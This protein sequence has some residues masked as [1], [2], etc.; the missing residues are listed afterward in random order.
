[1]G[2]VVSVVLGVLCVVLL[3]V[4]VILGILYG[5]SISR[6]GPGG[7]CSTSKCLADA[8]RIQR[9][10]NTSVDPCDNFYDFACGNFPKDTTSVFGTIGEEVLETVRRLLEEPIENNAANSTERKM[11]EYYASCL[12]SDVSEDQKM[13][14]LRDMVKQIGGFNPQTPADKI[15]K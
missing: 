12:E 5:T 14:T 6:K 10:L 9:Y 13:T 1:M 8:S 3:I 15:S 11:K 4:C 2:K 7:V